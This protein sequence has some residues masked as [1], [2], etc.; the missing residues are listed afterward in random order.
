M[1]TVGEQSLELD[2]GKSCFH[3]S[4]KYKP[5]PLYTNEIYKQA[6]NATVNKGNATIQNIKNS[7]RQEKNRS[8]HN[9]II[10]HLHQQSPSEQTSTS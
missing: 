8:Q 1:A 7:S 10:I 2:E 9:L 5:G 4:T 6:T 3:Y